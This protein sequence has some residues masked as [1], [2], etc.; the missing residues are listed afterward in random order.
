MELWNYQN[1]NWVCDECGQRNISDVT[2]GIEV[3]CGECG[4]ICPELSHEDYAEAQR[5]LEEEG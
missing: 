5:L 1:Y 4:T 3:D 2:A